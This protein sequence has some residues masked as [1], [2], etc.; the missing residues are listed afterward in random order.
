M[1]TEQNLRQMQ[2]TALISVSLLN[3]LILENLI[4]LSDK[5]T[6]SI[7]IALHGYCFPTRHLIRH[8]VK[9]GEKLEASLMT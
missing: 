9:W 1:L 7:E 6:R 5:I 3:M 4:K 2:A 8:V